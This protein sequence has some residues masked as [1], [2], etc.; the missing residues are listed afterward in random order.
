[1]VSGEQLESTALWPSLDIN[2]D[3]NGK[4]DRM[5]RLSLNKVRVVGVVKLEDSSQVDLSAHTADNWTSERTAPHVGQ[6]QEILCKDT[7]S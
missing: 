3:R 5:L 1:M 6:K 7:K 2:Q 4:S